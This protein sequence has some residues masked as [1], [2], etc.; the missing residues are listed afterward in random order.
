MH[1]ATKPSGTKTE[2]RSVKNEG[3]D[4]NNSLL[5]W[6][7]W[8]WVPVFQTT[9]DIRVASASTLRPACESWNW[10]AAA[11]QVFTSML[12]RASLTGV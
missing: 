5:P 11:Q 9:D 2:L 6:Q 1:H 4:V 10:C 3:A 7:V 12:R 8:H